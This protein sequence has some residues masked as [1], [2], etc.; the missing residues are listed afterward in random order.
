MLR[1]RAG[2]GRKLAEALRMAL[3]LHREGRQ[4]PASRRAREAAASAAVERGLP[5]AAGAK[6]PATPDELRALRAQG[7]SLRIVM[8]EL[9]ALAVAVQRLD[10]FQARL[11]G[12]VLH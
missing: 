9:D 10:D 11:P 3:P 6:G 7:L 8:P 5:A 1:E 4:A 12:V 2:A